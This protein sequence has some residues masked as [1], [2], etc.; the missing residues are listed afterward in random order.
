MQVELKHLEREGAPNS[1]E[2]R[3]LV[4]DNNVPHLEH[5]VGV[6]QRQGLVAIACTSYATAERLIES[7]RFDF[8]LL[9]QGRPSFEGRRLLERAAQAEPPVPVLVF[10][11]WA[12]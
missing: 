2:V 1:L 8:V 6:L 12:D 10:T 9:S 4:V 3:I 11:D 7:E 5:Q